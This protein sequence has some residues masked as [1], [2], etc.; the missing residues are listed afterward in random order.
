M[1]VTLRYSFQSAPV[2]ALLLCA[3]MFCASMF[4]VSTARA[5]EED[6]HPDTAPTKL[7]VK[8]TASWYQSS[9]GN[10][11]NDLNLRGNRGDHAAWIGVYR[12]HTPYQQ[13]RAGYEFVR[14][15]LDGGAAAGWDGDEVESHGHGDW[16]S[17]HSAR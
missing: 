17:V 13:A 12:D 3:S 4:C 11:A 5:A 6:E 14:H 10:D 2:A 7:D 15:R 16:V 9:D 8:L 1:T